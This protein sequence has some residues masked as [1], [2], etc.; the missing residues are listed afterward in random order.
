MFNGYF[1]HVT[2]VLAEVLSSKGTHLVE[3]EANDGSFVMHS[4][5][6]PSSGDYGLVLLEN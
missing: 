2:F 1:L 4:E 6:S 5:V 3:S